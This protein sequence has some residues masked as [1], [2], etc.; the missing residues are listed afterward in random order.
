MGLVVILQ[1]ISNSLQSASIL[2]LCLWCVVKQPHC[3]KNPSIYKSYN[4]HPHAVYRFIRRQIVF[5]DLDARSNFQR[6]FAKFH[7]IYIIYMFESFDD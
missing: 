3:L 1:L 6:L 2:I 4:V 5:L 7:N